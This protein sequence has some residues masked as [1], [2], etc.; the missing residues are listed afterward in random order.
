MK[1]RLSFA[2]LTAN[3]LLAFI[4]M[5]LVLSNLQSAAMGAAVI[6]AG[7]TIVQYFAPSLFAGKA[8]MALN[9]QV[10]TSDIIE[11]PFPDGSF[12]KKSKDLTEWV[13][14]DKIN[15]V[16]AGVEP[17]VY[18]DYFNGSED[19]LPLANINDIP[20]EVVLKTYSTEQTR[21]RDLQD[22]EL[23]YDKRSSIIKRHK[24]AL[25]RNMGVRAAFAWTPAV[26]NAFNKLATLGEN[27]SIIDAV[28]D[29]QAFMAGLDLDGDLNVCLTPVHM[30]RIR[31]EDKVL[32][33]DILNEKIMYGFNVFQYSQ[34]PLFTSA[35]V[36][37]PMGSAFEAGDKRASFFWASGEVFRAMG[38]VQMYA[39]L[40]DSAYQADTLSFA[41]RALIGAMRANNPKYFGAIV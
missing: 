25:D 1:K 7:T 3:F 8:L 4:V 16:E 13:D 39:N 6:T 27:D 21:H 34:T 36:K 11:N 31:K 10:W 23:Q 33:K 15:L 5:A 28:I 9:T 37:K 18:E 38:S 32:Y 35:N 17:A 22:V 30:A 19:P 12:I 26:D 20:H 2:A 24:Q 29:V 14:H 40:R 41:Q